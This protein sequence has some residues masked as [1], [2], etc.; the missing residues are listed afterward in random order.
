M[1]RTFTKRDKFK[2]EKVQKT[3]ID[4]RSKIRFMRPFGE[5]G[6]MLTAFLYNGR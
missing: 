2:N 6:L 3:M 4:M 1:K 5:A